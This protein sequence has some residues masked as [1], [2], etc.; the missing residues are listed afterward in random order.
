MQV[1]DGA[2]LRFQNARGEEG[3]REAW[4]GST[5]GTST[6]EVLP[7]EGLRAIPWCVHP[8]S[9][10]GPSLRAGC[11]RSPCWP[12]PQSPAW[13]QQR[14]LSTSPTLSVTSP[15]LGGRGRRPS[16]KQGLCQVRSGLLAPGHRGLICPFLAVPSDGDSLAQG[17]ATDHHRCTREQMLS[18]C[19]EVPRGEAFPAPATQATVCLPL[20]PWPLPAHLSVQADGN[21]GLG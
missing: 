21:C 16:S 4:P 13:P 1:L 9:P 10:R 17:S 6:Q 3:V 8:Q 19:S 15:R 5:A 14:P 18:L 7:W 12:G 2:V 20:L 11:L